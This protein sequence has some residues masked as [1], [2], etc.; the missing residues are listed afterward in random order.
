M[1]SNWSRVAVLVASACISVIACGEDEHSPSNTGG[2][3]GSSTEAGEGGSTSTAGKSNTGGK[4]GTGGTAGKGG[5][6]G[7]GGSNTAGQNAGGDNSSGSGNGG[8][9]GGSGPEE[10]GG[11]GGMPGGAGAGGDHGLPA[12]MTQGVGGEGAGG[13]PGDCHLQQDFGNQCAVEGEA[14]EDDTLLLYTTDF[15]DSTYPDQLHIELFK[16]TAPFGATIEPGDYPLTGDQTAYATCGACV[17]IYENHMSDVLYRGGYMATGGT[18]HI[19]AVSPSFVG[20]LENVTF[21]HVDLNTDT[22][23]NDGCDTKLSN[24]SF[25]TPVQ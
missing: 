11:M 17:L 3:S 5:S 6:S 12:C 4:G 2:S 24:L 7:S 15:S 1:R 21:A 14:I 10:M 25:N 13:Y 20:Y 19:T 8:A 23:V 18:L 9:G 22:P 16:N